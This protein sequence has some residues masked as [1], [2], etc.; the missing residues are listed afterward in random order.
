MTGF[1][2]P[3]LAVSLAQ[4]GGRGRLSVDVVQRHGRS[5][6]E[7]PRPVLVRPP[8]ETVRENRQASR[9]WEGRSGSYRRSRGVQKWPGLTGC[10]PGPVE[11]S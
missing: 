5:G 3:C 11:Y 2:R 8:C 4:G 1:G 6:R 7:C 10:G 9:P